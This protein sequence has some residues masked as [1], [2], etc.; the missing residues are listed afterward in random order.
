[1]GKANPTQWS[2]RFS[3]PYPRL[4][5]TIFAEAVDAVSPASIH[6][7]R[8]VLVDGLSATQAAEEA[9]LN[10]SGVWRAVNRL[11]AVM[12]PVRSAPRSARDFSAA[13]KTL[14]WTPSIH[15]AR[16]V[17]VDGLSAYAAAIE[18]QVHA[19]SVLRATY[20][21]V[22]AAKAAQTRSSSSRRKGR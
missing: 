20:R 7:A 21:L 19:S 6:A 4:S 9:G 22:D 1:M 12:P 11:R 18:A 2:P 14:I 3:R 5:A 13:V 10:P 16:R 17:L 8:R 15:A